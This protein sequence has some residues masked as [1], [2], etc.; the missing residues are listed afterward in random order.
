[1]IDPRDKKARKLTTQMPPK[2]GKIGEAT[3]EGSKKGSPYKF[4]G[5][6]KEDHKQP[7]YYICFCDQGPPYENYFATVG[8]NRATVYENKRDGSI[9]CV[10]SFADEDVSTL[11]I[12]ASYAL[13]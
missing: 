5:C 6:A 12:A 1:L 9:V 3:C 4:T 13:F 11:K 2:K 10:Q 7:I 8:A